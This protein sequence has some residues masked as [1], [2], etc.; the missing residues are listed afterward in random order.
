ML[1]IAVTVALAAYVFGPNALFRFLL[2]TVVP[3]RAVALSKSEEVYRA[4]LIS[5]A[6]LL[7][8]LL[9]AW[10]SG[11]LGHLWNPEELRTFFSGIYSEDYFRQNRGQWF[12]SLRWVY[13]LNLCV[14]WR[15]YVIDFLLAYALLKVIKHYARIREALQRIRWRWLADR[16]P[17]WLAALVLPRIAPWHVLLSD[18][19]VGDQSVQLHLD[20]MTKGDVLYQGVLADKS[21]APDG[22]LIFVV[23]AEPRRFKYPEYLEAKKQG[24]SPEKALFWKPIP[25][26]IFIITASEIAT[27]N[28]RYVPEDLGALKSGQEQGDDFQNE[29]DQLNVLVQEL[30]KQPGNN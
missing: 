18:I 20:I 7:C 4:F 28:L 6:C 24:L 22:T 21:L 8:A 19:E 5:G 30:L 16:S 13:S 3:R 1:A 2:D 14:L 11:T 29:L 15:L 9:W 27:M 23:L 26:N 17:K 12:H 10:T 25:T